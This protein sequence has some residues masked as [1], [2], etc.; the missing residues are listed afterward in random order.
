MI[1]REL[2]ANLSAYN[3]KF[4][5]VILMDVLEHVPDPLTTL[6]KVRP[7]LAPGGLVVI[8]TGDSCYWL[9]RLSLPFNGSLLYR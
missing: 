1:G 2:D 5:A 6:A 9:S 4:G 3:G 7:L 8:L